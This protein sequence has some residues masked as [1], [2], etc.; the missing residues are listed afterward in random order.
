MPVRPFDK[1]PYSSSDLVQL[2]QSRGLVIPDAKK[3]ER[4]LNVVGYYRLMGYGKYF[5]DSATHTFRAG[6]TY[7][8]IWNIYKFDRKLRL[9]TLDAIERIEVAIRTAISNEMSMAHGPHW[10]MDDALFNTL[11]GRND[12]CTTLRRE[13][14]SKKNEITIQYYNKYNTPDIP[15]S[16]M[17]MECISMGTWLKAF[18]DL[19]QVEQKRISAALGINNVSFTS[20]ANSLSWV[21]NVCAHHGILWNRTNARPP[22]VPLANMNYPNIAGKEASYFATAVIAYGFLKLIVSRSTWAKR[23]AAL[24]AEY[25]TVNSA[26]MGFTPGWDKDPFWK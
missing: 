12:F 20:W 19:K 26:A 24:M 16:W 22:R 11:Q 23:L 10:F 7:E 15:P 13:L 3:A 14:P 21:R 25:P 2:M 17:V 5:F 6:T 18:R 9:L 4:H 1:P 8:D